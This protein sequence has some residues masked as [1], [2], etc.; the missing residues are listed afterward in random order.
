MAE[1]VTRL[2]QVEKGSEKVLLLWNPELKL[3]QDGC[4]K[5]LLHTVH[6]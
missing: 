3:I 5:V 2:C 6:N 1:R 4:Q